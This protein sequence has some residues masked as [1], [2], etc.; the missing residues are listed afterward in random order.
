MEKFAIFVLMINNRLFLLLTSV[1][2]WMLAGSLAGCHRNGSSSDARLLAADSVLRDNP[3]SAL[4]LLDAIDISSLEGESNS[5]YHALLLT[6]A[7][8]RCYIP[9]TSDSLINI[10]LDYYN[11]HDEGREKLTRANIYKG[12]VMEELGHPELAMAYYKR[13]QETVMP[14]DHFNQGYICLRMGQIYNDSYV[15]DSIDVVKYKEALSHFSLVPDSFYMINTMS[16]L[17]SSYAGKSQTNNAVKYLELAVALAKELHNT[18]LEFVTVRSLTD[19]KM[20]SHDANDLEEAKRIALSLLNHENNMP[21]EDKDH[22]LMTAA[23]TLAKLNKPDSA[24][25]YLNLVDRDSSLPGDRVFYDRCRAEIAISKGN[26]GQYQHYY[27][28]ADEHADS[29]VTNEL[30]QRLKEVETKYDNEKLKYLSLRYHS[31]WMLSLLGTAL[32]ISVLAIVMMVMKRKLAQRHR[33]LR[34]NE[35]T[36]E[37]LRADTALLSS[38]LNTNLTM[39]EN[40]KQTISHQINVFARLIE[41]HTMH[42]A[43]SPKKFSDKFAQAYRMNQPDASFWTGIRAFADSQYNSLITNVMQ[44]YPSLSDS[45]LNFLSLYCCDL[46]T[47]VIMACM[48]YR[49]AHSVYNKKRRIATV[50]GCSNNL[51]VFL[52]RYKTFNDT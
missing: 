25:H 8:Y 47:T 5:A 28:L 35:D 27:E 23:F 45:D 41:I 39:S 1:M 18:E 50:L 29:L 40:L 52:L 2:L 24:A 36:I 21:Q 13:A 16:A 31:N 46:P 11:Q 38:Q 20:F 6:Q 17:G 51:D 12:A 43:Y 32:I 14:D 3:D 37:R 4:Q 22:F 42:F 33:Q 26:I 30:Q 34:E 10:A 49:E 15:A 48:G 7:R 9:A 19:L 44:Q